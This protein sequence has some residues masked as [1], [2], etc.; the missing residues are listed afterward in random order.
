[1]RK[2]KFLSFILLAVL[3]F[4]S[5]SCAAWIQELK[6]NP[7]L[8]LQE[9]ET[10]IASALSLATSA[11]NAFAATNPSAVDLNTQAEFNRIAS[12]VSQGLVLAND[13][14][15]IAQHAGGPA[16]DVNALLG[17]AR[18]S[19]GDLATFLATIKGRASSATPTP[20]TNARAVNQQMTR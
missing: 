7:V 2:N 6:T 11:F 9:A 10:Y 19:M 1:M 13:G 14:L 16:P 5:S 18:T 8:A 4:S 17:D 15:R 20:S 3:A 12:G